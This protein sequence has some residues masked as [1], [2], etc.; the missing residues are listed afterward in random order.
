MSGPAPFDPNNLPIKPIRAD[1]GH[2]SDHF[3]KGHLADPDASPLTQKFQ[4][5]DTGFRI[6][7][8]VSRD[9]DVGESS[10]D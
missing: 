2:V 3:I 6:N 8:D 1:L 4:Y 5:H 7:T 9:G 10:F